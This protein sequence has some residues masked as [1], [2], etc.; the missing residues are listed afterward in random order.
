M[1]TYFHEQE[2]IRARLGG[3]D[4]RTL[5]VLADRY[6]GANPPVPFAFRAFNRDGI[7][8]NEEGLF[9]LDLGR[10]FPEAKQG[11]ISYA[12]SLVWSD[13]DRNLDVLLRCLGPVQF[14]FNG[15]LAYRS[16]V[17]DELKPDATVKLNLDFAKGWNRLWIKAKHTAAGFGCLFG[18]DEAKVRILNVRSPFAERLGQAGWVYSAP[19]DADVFEGIALPNPFSSEREHGLAWLPE[20]RWR[21]EELALL[22]C[23]R[24][25]GVQP[26]RTA[27]AW[28]V[29]HSDRPGAA[30]YV[31]K[32]TSAGPAT[33]WVDG[34]LVADVPAAGSF[35]A[36]VEL[37]Y[38]R[39][40]VLVCSSCGPQSWGFTLEGWA[41]GEPAPFRAPADVHGSSGE[42]WFYL[43]PFDASHDLDVNELLTMKRVFHNQYWRLDRPQTWIRPYYE[44]AMLSNKWTVGNATNFGRWD[45]P[46]GVTI[47][48][49]LQTGRL[50]GRPDIIAYALEHVQS[51]TDMYE[52]SL[53]DR[54][55]YGFPAIN[56]QLVMMKMLDNCGSFGSAMLESHKD[57]ANAGYMPIAQRIG[58]FMLRELERKEDGAFYRVCQDEYSANTMWADDLYMSTP[59][60]CRYAGMT[61]NSEALDEAAR[62]FLLFRS[63]LYMPKQRMMSHVF[64]FKYGMPTRIPWGRGNG[65][66]LFSLTEVLEALPEDHVHRAELVAFFQELCAGYAEVQADSGLWHQVLNDPDAYQEASC[67]AMF[68]YAYARGVR[69][70]WLR[71]P[72]RFVRAALRAWDGLTRYA[73]DG[74]GNVHGVCSGSR[75]AFTADYYKKDLLTVTNDNH[76]VGIM[77]LAGTELVKLKDWL[78]GRGTIGSAGLAD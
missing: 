70:G 57:D 47:Y 59:F 19:V 28:S 18:S 56:Q 38:G 10:R 29:L 48:G 60:L 2:S 24:M 73:I 74:Q 13:S 54:A 16:N 77:M 58:N 49:L 1:T 20:G 17:M 27:Y 22:N 66:T 46:L 44:N 32:G 35:Q 43:G 53:W 6:I 7:L 39:H 5:K 67:T 76:G 71:E 40:D 30:P 69:F 36:E 3:D 62:Q 21:E 41:G 31:L 11:Q 50:L 23:E 37:V 14:Y 61:G 25:F 75:Y 26:G 78:G 64:D 15:E 4:V 68:A 72:E 33:V 42:A 45:Y 8:Q 51:C 52:Y 12:Y 9:D 63:Y 65:W 55:Q 34:R